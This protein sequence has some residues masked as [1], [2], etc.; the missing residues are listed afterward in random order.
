M[1]PKRKAT[2]QPTGAAVELKKPR[3][4]NDGRSSTLIP[5]G[6]RKVAKKG[7]REPELLR[8]LCQDKVSGEKK[9]LHFKKLVHADIDWYNKD[10]IDKINAWRNQ[11]YGRA[12]IKQKTVTMWTKDEEAYVE[13]YWQLL[14][15]EANKRGILMP[16]P[17]VIREDFNN[18]FKGTRGSGPFTSKMAR[19]TK[20]LKPYLEGKLLGHRGD[21][22]Y[23]KITQDMV[24]EYRA[25]KDDL[26]KLGCKD[27]KV[28]PWNE[29]EDETNT[30]AHVLRCRAWL[31]SLPD[32]NDVQMKE[33]KEEEE[34]A[35]LVG[36]EELDKELL[37][38]AT[39]KL[40]S[41][42]KVRADSVAPA[43]GAVGH[44]SEITL[45]GEE[46][47]VEKAQGTDC[48]TAEA[49][50]EGAQAECLPDSDQEAAET[51]LAF[52]GS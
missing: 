25:L 6:E 43:A 45:V 18:F 40:A 13:L 51:L 9:E 3:V 27:D 28:I 33:P 26:V 23:P 22:Y 47:I 41:P 38:L 48:V 7:A 21:S 46:V 16:K 4:I 12:G 15:A 52:Y 14:V 20:G 32:L 37:E 11:I 10:H 42:S 31:S 29:V 5:V 49:S 17:K 50:D 8:M 30:E 19:L 36:F 44:D 39:G 1:S 2:E 24:S 34:D 35:T